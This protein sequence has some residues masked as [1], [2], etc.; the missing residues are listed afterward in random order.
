MKVS[1]SEESQDMLRMNESD[2]CGT[3]RLQS[4]EIRKRVQAGDPTP[5]SHPPKNASYD[6]W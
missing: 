6:V 5:T 1:R 4:V 3:Q 2:P